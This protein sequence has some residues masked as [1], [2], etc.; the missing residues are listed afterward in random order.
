MSALICRFLVAVT[1]IAATLSGAAAAEKLNDRQMKEAEQFAANNSLFVLYHE[2]AHL[3]VDQLGLPVLGKEED[4]ADNM[5]SYTLLEKHSSASDRV[6]SDAAYGWL[7]SGKAY[8]SDFED[9]DFY[10]SHGFD[11]QR[12]Y[13]IVCLMVGSNDETFDSIADSYKIDEERQDT[14]KDEYQLL[15]RSLDGLLGQYIDKNGKGTEVRVTYHA[16]SGGL[17][18]AADA[19]KTSG[20]FEEVA[21]EIRV[22]YALPKKVAF[23][24]KR[25]GEANA[26]YDPD[27]VEV[28]FCY[29]LMDEFITMISEDMPEEAL[30]GPSIGLGRAGSARS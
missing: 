4:A 9:S 22:K 21:D 19:F 24:A 26:Y 20:V 5:A 29:E 2:V 18:R 6:I 7:L 23:R 11:K 28:I 12:A 3:L 30:P 16:A 1:L 17:K 27:T 13:Q 15:K 10:D 8:G 14:C 25:C